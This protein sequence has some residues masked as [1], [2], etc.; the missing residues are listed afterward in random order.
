MTPAPSPQRGRPG[1]RLARFYGA[2]LANPRRALFLARLLIPLCVFT[3]L[4]A[5]PFLQW[6][7]AALYRFPSPF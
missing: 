3:G 4:A 6:L 7:L 2:L 1:A 5:Q